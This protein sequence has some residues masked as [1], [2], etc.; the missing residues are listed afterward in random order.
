MRIDQAG[1]CRDTVG[2][3]GLVGGFTQAVA[4]G[5]DNAIFDKQR[6]RPTQRI[7]QF[8]RDQRTDVSDQNGQH[9]RDYSKGSKLEKA[10][11][12]MTARTIKCA[13]DLG[14]Q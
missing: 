14:L 13:G 10:T 5:L 8:P 11:R 12:R 4:D 2:V 1:D 7:L 6:I 9:R 3:D